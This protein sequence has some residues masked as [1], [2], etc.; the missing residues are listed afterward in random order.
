MA[1]LEI[2]SKEKDIVLYDVAPDTKSLKRALAVLGRVETK[3]A[4]VHIG[5]LFL[6]GGSIREDLEALH[7]KDV[8]L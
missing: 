1:L 7:G 4:I 8:L 2:A 5:E 3:K 6:Y